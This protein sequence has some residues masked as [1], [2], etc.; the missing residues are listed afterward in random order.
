VSSSRPLA[1]CC[2]VKPLNLPD[3]DVRLYVGFF[4][5]HLADRMLR[6]LLETT[7]WRQDSFRLYGKDIPFPRLTAWY[8]DLGT[9]YVYSGITNVPL[10]WTPP[11]LEVKRAVE[12]ACGLTFNSVL[13]NRYRTGKDSVSWHADDEPEFGENPVIA[14]VSFG[15]T[16]VFQLKHKKRKE[17]KASI[18]LTHGSLLV[19]R[20]RTQ[21]N[22]LHQIPKTAKSVDERLNLTFRAVIRPTQRTVRP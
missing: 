10:P 16:R 21:A 6:E 7:D 12:P 17:L 19:M 8:G 11:I 2:S 1:A 18:E 20:A 3:A 9:S 13:L 5:A 15:G 22:W 4:P 14:S